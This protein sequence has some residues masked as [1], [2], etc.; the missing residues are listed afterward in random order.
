MIFTVLFLILA[1]F[2]FLVSL[3]T[4]IRPPTN[5]LWKV[6]IF[7][8]EGGHFLVIP[9]IIMA[10]LA[11]VTSVNTLNP[12]ISLNSINPLLSWSGFFGAIVSALFLAAAILF[13]TPLIRA[14]FTAHRLEARFTM[15]F[16]KHLPNDARLARSAPLQWKQLFLGIPLPDANPQTL[17]Y[18]SV[19]QK[20]YA[21]DFYAS[22]KP[23]APC[24][25]VIHGGGWDS[26]NRRDLEP[27]N[28]YLVSLG[29]AVAA[30]D[31]GLAPKH[32][33]PTQVNDLKAAIAYLELNA[34]RLGIDI[35]RL[36]LLGR[37]AGGQIAMQVA[38]D[39]TM[40]K[41]IKGVVGYYTPADMVY[42][43]SVPC[44]PLIL[45]SRKLMENYLGGSYTQYPEAYLN[46]SP[47]EFLNAQSPATL[48]LHGHP[49]E[50]VAYE[51]SVRMEAKLNKLGISHFTVDLPWAT[52]GF[53]YV[54]S[55]PGSQVSLFFL[56]RFLAQVM[57]K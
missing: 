48:L 19:N 31:Y 27:L 25:L 22:Q 36:V 35:N 14:I 41:R 12:S 21:L 4:V 3:L 53:D 26:G 52:H 46:S 57:A 56:E 51:H 38:Y 11:W 49:D 33:Y 37:S 44:N 7:A 43:Y 9:C 23:Q 2:I 5:L 30:V 8:Q 13:S 1:G 34:Q 18:V 50:L 55:G 6:S 10:G 45:D 20:A 24:I 32:K 47:I 54:F 28:R 17:Q 29:Y 15:G 40:V 42:G 16:G 39:P